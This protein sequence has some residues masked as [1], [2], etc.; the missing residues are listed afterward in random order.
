MGSKARPWK[1]GRGKQQGLETRGKEKLMSNGLQTVFTW[2][3][4]K[5]SRHTTQSEVTFPGS[6]TQLKDSIGTSEFQ[7]TDLTA[8]PLIELLLFL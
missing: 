2:H 1:R 4:K 8:K 3:Y 5:Y 6:T 7:K